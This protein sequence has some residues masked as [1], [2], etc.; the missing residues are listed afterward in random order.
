VW[1]HAF[2]HQIHPDSQ[3]VLLS[4]WA[5]GPH[6]P[7]STLRSQLRPILKTNDNLEF[8]SRLTN[9]LRE[10]D[11][12]FV[13]S[14]KWQLG[15]R[16]TGWDHLLTF[17][18]PSIRDFL[19]NRV[20]RDASLLAD[21]AKSIITFE[22]AARLLDACRVHVEES[23]FRAVHR[24]AILAAWD[25]LHI[26]TLATDAFADVK[27][28]ANKTP[29]PVGRL[30]TLIS[31]SLDAD[32]RGRMRALLCE[33]FSSTTRINSLVL[34][35]SLEE[36]ARLLHTSRDALLTMPDEV[37]G[38]MTHSLAKLGEDRMYDA[39]SFEE[40]RQIALSVEEDDPLRQLVCEFPLE[41]RIRHIADGLIHEA[42]TGELSNA[43][44]ADELEDMNYCGEVFGIYVGK[45]RD[46]LEELLEQDE[47]HET[48]RAVSSQM[49][50]ADSSADIYGL[51]RQLVEMRSGGVTE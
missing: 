30:L 6:V 36:A 25:L 49:A 45:W 13:Q 12:N 31:Y 8:N 17:H 20:L 18:N 5:L 9:A 47:T 27:Y 16:P 14:S 32:E 7:L 29:N 46:A 33:I 1:A 50:P 28:L 48:V 21:V 2:D 34:S 19:N 40:L 41:D 10:L 38:S 4:L 22:Q 23:A 44:I 15:I 26:P 35:S 3:R 24:A 51:F 43:R 37:L 39:S 11:G 42:E